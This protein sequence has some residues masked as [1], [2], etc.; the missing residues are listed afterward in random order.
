MSS[1]YGPSHK[2]LNDPFE[3]ITRCQARMGSSNGGEPYTQWVL[4]VLRFRLFGPNV[5]I[6]SG[7][8]LGLTAS[9]VRCRRWTGSIEDHAGS[10]TGTPS[11]LNSA[12]STGFR[13][14]SR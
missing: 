1:S 10:S 4:L 3:W 12:G 14:S 8:R 6:A 11:R 2:R 9:I 5:L 7:T 13:D